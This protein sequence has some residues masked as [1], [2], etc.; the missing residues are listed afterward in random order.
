[1]PSG[2]KLNYRLDL[3]IECVKLFGP[4]NLVS[5]AILYYLVPAKLLG[6][7]FTRGLW[8]YFLVLVYLWTWDKYG[9][10]KGRREAK[11]LGAV[12]IPRVKGKWPGNLDLGKRM[13]DQIGESYFTEAMEQF[14]GDNDT[15]NFGALWT[16]VYVTRSHTVTQ[17]V[18]AQ[19]FE[20]F[21]KGYELRSLLHGLLGEG[22]FA[23][24]GAE[25]KT[26][27]AVMRPFFGKERVRDLNLLDHYVEKSVALIHERAQQGLSIDVQDLFRRFTMDAAGEFLFGSKDFNTLDRP[28]PVPSSVGLKANAT[29]LDQGP[30]GEL[31]LA[32]DKL[33][34]IIA[35]RS[36]SGR[37]WAIREFWKDETVGYNKVVDRFVLPLVHKALNNK[38][39]RGGKKCDVQDGNFVDHLADAVSDVKVIRDGLFNLLIA[40]RD[41]TASMLTFTVYLLSLHPEILAKLRKEVVSIVPSGPPTFDDM[42]KMPL[43]RA[44]LNESLRLFPPAP[45]NARSSKS[46]C[47]VPGDKQSGGKPYYIPGS[48]KRVCYLTFPLH[49]KKDVW[50][51]DAEE[52]V[53]DRWIDKDE[54][55]RVQRPHIYP[56]GAGPRICPGQEFAYIESSIMMIRILQVFDTF[57]LRQK[58]D[59]PPG[60][61]PPK[62]WEGAPGRK[63]IEQIWPTLAVVLYIKVGSRLYIYTR[64]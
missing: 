9:Q 63:G 23:S 29:E 16:D 31:V 15:I 3:A 47:L 39:L 30:Y 6:G 19:T 33:Q 14:F 17:A 48:E 18:L 28:L 41:T 10:W 24:D 1:M 57:T 61:L 52:F 35:I 7:Y 55:Q 36:I 40:A 51:E 34:E 49:R 5:F 27:R 13:L 2:F 60:S 56:F 11:K 25:A 44:V 58:E 64:E 59:A 43:L 26:H 54:T 46:A 22:I 45:M 4:P 62:S 21:H 53:P 32:F 38:K 42:R 50:G 8:Q 20:T 37:W 12:F